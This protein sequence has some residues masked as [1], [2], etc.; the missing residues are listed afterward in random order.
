MMESEESIQMV[1][2]DMQNSGAISSTL[3]EL[4]EEQVSGSVLASLLQEPDRSQLL[5]VM[6]VYK[7]CLSMILNS[8]FYKFSG[9]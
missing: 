8:R 1:I 9:M 2:H 5:T 6:Q 4:S 7:I 3:S